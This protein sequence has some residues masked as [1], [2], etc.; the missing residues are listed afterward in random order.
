MLFFKLIQSFILPSV[1]TFLL[2][3]LGLIFLFLKKKKI[4]KILITIGII[5]LYIFSIT[6]FSDILILPLENQYKIP[7]K[8]MI[9][10]TDKLVLLLGGLVS[11]DLPISSAL[12]NSTLKRG[13]EATLIYLSRNS[14]M[15]IIISGSD[16]LG[17]SLDKEGIFVSKLMRDFGI[18]EEDIILETQSKNTYESA[19]NLKEILGDDKFILLT[20]AYHIPRSMDIF[21]KQGFD[22]IA[23]PC[24]FQYQGHLSILDFLPDPKNLKKSNL[25]FHEYF[26]ILF[27]RLFY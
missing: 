8:N 20:S 12:S 6:P 15:K 5:F 10:S 7:D 1:F 3:L 4:A 14:Q 2:I 23:Y 16:P 21:K 11:E 18:E 27:Y 22:P 26:G 25:A 17:L 19:K 9:D 13:V 24:D